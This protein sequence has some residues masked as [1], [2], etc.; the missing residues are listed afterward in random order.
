MLSACGPPPLVVLTSRCLSE[1][2][3][4]N[5]VVSRCF[6]GIPFYSTSVTDI[7]CT[8]KPF[9]FLY[10]FCRDHFAIP[11]QK[12]CENCNNDDDK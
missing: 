9:S 4:L 2:V 5:A 10:S 12:G 1:R 8:F 3:V 6:K 11:D 7:E